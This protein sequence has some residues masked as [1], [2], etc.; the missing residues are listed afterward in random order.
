MQT[1]VKQIELT[2][3]SASLAPSR[4]MY[5]KVPSVPLENQPDISYLFSH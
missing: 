4:A 3:T 2:D 1:N 5:H